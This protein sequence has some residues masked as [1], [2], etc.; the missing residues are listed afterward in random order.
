MELIFYLLVAMSFQSDGKVGFHKPVPYAT[1]KECLYNRTK[2]LG[3]PKPNSIIAYDV[4]CAKMELSSGS[5]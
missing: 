4:I 1:E 5:I 3:A 2:M